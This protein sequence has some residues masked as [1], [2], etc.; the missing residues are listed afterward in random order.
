MDRIKFQNYKAFENGEIELRPLTLL[1][2]ANSSGKSSILH[3]LLMLEQTINC[4]D[5][6]KSAFKANGHSVSMGEDINLL[7]D[8]NRQSSMVLEIDVPPSSFISEIK[9]FH[10]LLNQSS[11]LG[12][13]N[14]LK[15]NSP[16]DFK[17]FEK[18]SR[19]WME[20][21]TKSENNKSV[22]IAKT[23][24]EIVSKDNDNLLS[25]LL[26]TEVAK[27]KVR[28]EWWKKYTVDELS[29]MISDLGA[30]FKTFEEEFKES[31][32]VVSLK[33]I[34]SYNKTQRKL[35]VKECSI[36]VGDR[37][38]LAISLYR[39]KLIVTSK[40]YDNVC[41]E[42]LVG[43]SSFSGIFNGLS[44]NILNDMKSPFE[45][46]I[47]KI[48]NEAF[49]SATHFFSE[50]NI[51]Y[52]GPLRATPQ[53]Y[54]FL[55]GTNTISTFGYRSGE[56]IAEI[57]KGSKDI[58]NMVNEWMKRFGLNVKVKEFKDVIHKIKV[59]QNSLDLDLPDVGFGVSQILPI[60][61]DGVLFGDDTTTIMEQP[62]IHLHPK[63][64]A[65][66]AD[67][68]INVVKRNN[69]DTKKTTR[70]YVIETHSEY[71]MKRIR[72]RIAEG[73]IAPE[74]VAIYFVEPRNK[75]L[76]IEARINRTIVENDGTIEWPKDF[77]MTELEDEMAFFQFKMNK[78]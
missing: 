36:S 54:Y 18:A 74:D 44:L 57:L 55:D 39:N 9:T 48:F 12:F 29:Q 38:L 14:N 41:I 50:T 71:I 13:M 24:L 53:R 52:I 73:V 19:E 49:K 3:L 72:R 2:G 69:N 64:Q 61:I 26:E 78:S 40:V 60:L 22:D 70:R 31:P 66:L 30:C 35:K 62:E 23:Y 17:I 56:R 1:L 45:V 51:N 27:Q 34:L 43:P 5:D 25:Y 77:Y 15:Y 75:K 67:F 28:N 11:I 8:M 65:E 76:K 7:K 37:E 47:E 20:Q 42:R 4:K 32:S 6:L 46:Y 58:D 21:I 33:Y 10:G 16:K 63:M 59:R 68:F